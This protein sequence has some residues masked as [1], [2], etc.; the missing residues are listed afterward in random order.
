MP[1]DAPY[2][3]PTWDTAATQVELYESSGGTRGTSLGGAPCVILTTLGRRS[4]KA[5][6]SPLVRVEHEGLYCAVASM[7][8]APKH[9]GWYHNLCA[10]PQVTLQDGPVVTDM[11]ARTVEG[12]EREEWWAR[13]TA[14]W[15]AYDDYQART[16]RVIPVVVLTPA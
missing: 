11:V 14:V 12:A 3:P 8:G 1:I 13:A 5:R 4:G 7:G 15:P 6:K 2:E 9:P 10:H 16:E